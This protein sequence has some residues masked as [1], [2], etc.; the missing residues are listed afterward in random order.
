MRH[1]GQ[2]ELFAPLVQHEGGYDEEASPNL[3]ELNAE[4][5]SE[6]VLFFLVTPK[7][8]PMFWQYP[9]A[10]VNC[11]ML[12]FGTTQFPSPRS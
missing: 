8:V 10:H 7:R 1:S 5:E 11:T 9:Q 6:V 3:I 12:T 4:A 2:S